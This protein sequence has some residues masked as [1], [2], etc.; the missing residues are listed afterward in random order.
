MRRIVPERSQRRDRLTIATLCNSFK[1]NHHLRTMLISTLIVSIMITGSFALVLAGIWGESAAEGYEGDKITIN[2]HP[3]K[4]TAPS[5]RSN[6]NDT[7][8]PSSITV[9]YYGS[10]ASTEYNPQVWSNDVLQ[11]GS[12]ILTQVSDLST[13]YSIK[14]YTTNSTYVF[15]GWV[16]NNGRSYDPGDIIRSSDVT[17]ESFD[18]YATWNLLNRYSTSVR[19]NW[20]DGTP[21]TNLVVG[22]TITASSSGTSVNGNYT[23][24]NCTIN[25]SSG[26]ININKDTII[27]S[28]TITGTKGG[29]NHGAGSVGLFANGHKL[30]IGSKVKG[31]Q[32]GS[33]EAAFAQIFGGSMSSALSKSTNLIIHSGTYS[34]VV[35]GSQNGTVNGNV[36]VIV[37]D[38]TILDTLTAGVKN[39][40]NITGSTYIY[41]TA[42]NMPGDT[43]EE[44]NLNGGVDIPSGVTLKESTILT[45]GSNKGT[46]NG[47]TNVYITGTSKVWDVQGAGRGGD[48]KVGGTANVTIGGMAL[49]KH[50]IAGSITDGLSAN[51]GIY[52]N[53]ECVKNTDIRVK[54][55]SKVCSVF[56]AG[57]D[58]FYKAV[59]ASMLNGGSI[60][61]T[62]EG[63]PTVGYIYGGGYRGTIGTQ[64]QPI[65]SISID[66]KGG[67]VL[68]DVFGGGRG[69]LDKICHEVNGTRNWGDSYNDS[70]GYSVVYCRDI[71]ISVSEGAVVKG[72][73]YGGGESVPYI[74]AYDGNTGLSGN[75]DGITDVVCVASVIADRTVID[76]KGTIE[77][78]VF[79][80]G[81]GVDPNEKDAENRH[82]SAYIF[83]MDGNG[84][85]K[86]IVWLTGSGSGTTVSST[87]NHNNYASV[88]SNITINMQDGIV[89]G[90]VYG[91]GSL[92]KV[93]GTNDINIEMTNG[94]IQGSVYGGGMGSSS[95]ADAGL[96]D[97][98]GISIDLKGGSIQ[99]SVYGGGELAKTYTSTYITINI[100]GCE[101]ASNVFGG[102]LGSSG[103][104]S[105]KSNRRITLQSGRV[106]G[107]L[108]GSSSLGDDGTSTQR[109]NSTVLMNGGSVEGSLYGGGFKGTMYGNTSITIYG[110]TVAYSV[111]G[112]ADVG[113]VDP[114]DP[115]FN[116]TLVHGNS[117]ILVDGT[118]RSL[119]IGRSIFGSG[120]SCLVS[121]IKDV[122]IIGATLTSMD[123][124]QNVDT[125]SISN[126]SITL[127]GRSDATTAQASTRYSINNIGQIILRE[128][129]VFGLKSPTNEIGGYTSE[130]GTESSPSNKIVLY[131]G[132][133]LKVSK[134]DINGDIVYGKISGHTILQTDSSTYGGAFAYGSLESDGNFVVLRDGNYIESYTRDYSNP[135]CRCWYIAGNVTYMTTMIADGRVIPQ[136]QIDVPMQNSD[137]YLVFTGFDK[138]IPDESRF[139]LKDSVVEYPDFSMKVYGGAGSVMAGG[140]TLSDAVS[141]IGSNYSNYVMSVEG[142]LPYAKIELMGASTLRYTGS[143]ATV[144]IH[145]KEMKKNTDDTYSVV[146]SVDVIVSIHTE[147]TEFPIAEGYDVTIGTRDGKGSTDF[148][149]NRSFNGYTATVESI[150]GAGTFSKITMESYLNSEGTLGWATPLSGKMTLSTIGTG[151]TIGDLTGSFSATIRFTADC[152][153]STDV[154]T[155]TATLVIKL[156]NGNAAD[157]KRIL[158]RLSVR[159]VESH[160]VTFINMDESLTRE[161]RTVISVYDNE[162]IPE[163]QKPHTWDHFINWYSDV[164]RNNVFDFSSPINVDTVV[165]SS[166][167]YAVHF[168]DGFGGGWTSYVEITAG[169]TSIVKPTDPTRPSYTFDKWVD[170][171]GVER[172]TGDSENIT[173]DT[174]FYALWIGQDVVVHLVVKEDGSEIY[175]MTG[176]IEFGKTYSTI[177]FTSEGVEY[178][179]IDKATEIVK[180]KYPEKGRF[181]R[182]VYENGTTTT[183]VYSDTVSL[184]NQEHTL[185]AEFTNE[186][187]T[188]RFLEDLPNDYKRTQTD[189]EA[190]RIYWYGDWHD[191][192]RIQA[193]TEMVVFKR[194]D[195]YKFRPG[196]ASFTGYTLEYWTYTLNGTTY[197]INPT[198][199]VTLTTVQQ[200]STI[201]VY[202]HWKHIDYV[203]NTEV[204]RGGSIVAT[205]TTD[206]GSVVI[207]NGS[208]LWHG[209][210]VRIQYVEGGGYTFSRWGQTGSS[211]FDSFTTNPANL[212]IT[213]DTT[214]HV[215]LS[216]VYEA[217]VR[218]SVNGMLDDGRTLQLR[219]STTT[220][221]YKLTATTDGK[222][223]N[224]SVRFGSYVVQLKNVNGTWD[225]VAEY[226]IT[227]PDT[228]CEVSLY[229]ITINGG[230]GKVRGPEFSTSDRMI[231]IGIDEGYEATIIGKVPSSLII[232]GTGP[233][234]FT[235]PSAAV[236]LTFD[237]SIIEYTVDFD[238]NGGTYSPG[239]VPVIKISYFGTYDIIDIENRVSKP[240]FTLGGWG[241]WIG[242]VDQHRTVHH[243]DQIAVRADHTLKAIWIENGKA[244]YTIKIYQMDLNG[245]YELTNTILES[246]TIGKT[247]TVDPIAIDGFKTPSSVSGV[248]TGDGNLVLEI[249][250]E[251]EKYRV[252]FDIHYQDGFY[253]VDTIVVNDVYFGTP[254]SDI[255][256]TVKV[257]FLTSETR[258]DDQYGAITDK[259]PSSNNGK[260]TIYVK[261][262]YVVYTIVYNIGEG[263]MEPPY[264]VEYV[265][266][267]T[268]I[269][270]PTPVWAGYRFGGWIGIGTD[271]A[272]HI[273][274]YHTGTLALTAK[275]DRLPVITIDLNAYGQGISIDGGV[276]VD[277]RYVLN[278]LTQI[279]TLRYS[280]ATE[281]IYK[282]IVNG[283]PVD[284][285]EDGSFTSEISSD[286]F[287]MAFPK[288]RDS[289]PT[290]LVEMKVILGF[291][292]SDD[293][294]YST[295]L[296]DV[297]IYKD[298]TIDLSRYGF[299]AGS[300]ITFGSNG[301]VDIVGLDGL[302]G[303]L[304]IKESTDDYNVEIVVYISPRIVDT[305]L[306]TISL[307]TLNDG[308]SSAL[309]PQT[310]SNYILPS[311]KDEDMIE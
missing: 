122:T 12:E 219:S 202:P 130:G 250:Y 311:E 292:E 204:P 176:G 213:S 163:S 165:Y 50:I 283:V 60:R 141:S 119:S 164:G 183:G 188:V 190:G 169:G 215:I 171:N 246:D 120:N 69:G 216:G 155:S 301:E 135:P 230:D 217:T 3:F 287:V 238:L 160:T 297:P 228:L 22:P 235:M 268:D 252:T 224:S 199:T 6:Y 68:N 67:T 10:I 116:R 19:S 13:W 20:S 241:V 212:M 47:D 127:S 226:T 123:S 262:D 150:E 273:P 95:N 40:V 194:D 211:V 82:P 221:T 144:T 172:F 168:D 114:D 37:K 189:T 11:G 193:P 208:I 244:Q 258:I 48:S 196:N 131:G 91:G 77:G 161:V 191:L 201:D 154:P 21:Y 45:G 274:A 232:E 24:R 128:N 118:G 234:T 103:N 278:D 308:R 36:S 253:P 31:S 270:L 8:I 290:P 111:Y 177:R 299:G 255:G 285:A 105:T 43:Y 53:K 25:V 251:R 181:I 16:D 210:S 265:I 207:G 249:R 30:I 7:T 109:Y 214:I 80:A 271:P 247:V 260:V 63:Q 72:N 51:S 92:G 108:F 223:V 200:G 303:Y 309:D 184:N 227:G 129:V 209:D 275:Y 178:V 286:T 42:L 62:M 167:R 276:F 78:S 166:Y 239:T 159:E 304:L 243:G 259:I 300:S 29:D 57:Y 59:Y 73:V 117:T 133:P 284:P 179:G 170:V 225:D 269:E 18:L 288:Y 256:Y 39:N 88:N 263:S 17:G 203:F 310:I 106:M 231:T 146:N 23:L 293:G 26:Y 58:T 85:I 143:V 15:T 5:V 52:S 137:S 157:D 115:V 248:V 145:L 97:V 89:Q 280:S 187:I 28:S 61:V 197:R 173:T 86:S 2:Y 100:N 254:I 195:G 44:N 220:D 104:L 198:E 110:G 71:N 151:R 242:G 142:D 54:D 41:A 81:K 113:D 261:A 14:R 27:D 102:G 90:S 222:Y 257:G 281:V 153:G 186:A 264:I 305:D 99:R 174:T 70:T 236:E 229:T 306:S 233:Y 162:I 267:H 237:V 149:I 139:R 124:I 96:V 65:D 46:I 94:V 93:Y 1:G 84:D 101:I 38:V 74:T 158:I 4:G 180:A 76:I 298:F 35:A 182:W 192:I 83:A 152:D 32:S 294:N 107:S 125:L 66:I 272:T 156:S 140:L 291:V 245:A 64:T 138:V 205:K 132:L 266:S 136:K 282:W 147:A 218:L 121:G 87:V 185:Y 277:G 98:R 279:V 206:G 175:R 296:Q 34:N 307:M 75:Y 56:G 112:G 33:T 79:G 295:V 55:Q 134:K 49:V 240:G 126:S 148:I 289:T 9:T 302:T